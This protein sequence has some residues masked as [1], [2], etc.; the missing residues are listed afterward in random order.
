MSRRKKLTC[1]TQ[2]Y[3]VWIMRQGND[4]FRAKFP[5]YDGNNLQA[6][7]IYSQLTPTL[8]TFFKSTQPYGPKG[9]E[10]PK[11]YAG[12]ALPR[13]A[14]LGRISASKPLPSA[15]SPLAGAGDCQLSCDLHNLRNL[16][17]RW[18]FQRT[19]QLRKDK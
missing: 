7:R 18:L 8:M 16:A 19:A 12:M 10:T 6:K 3:L 4:R 1:L 14:R 11:A 9:R 2:P 13:R 5:N 15:A 17:L